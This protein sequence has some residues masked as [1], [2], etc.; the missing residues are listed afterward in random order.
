MKFN[1]CINLKDVKKK[2]KKKEQKGTNEHF[3]FDNEEELD[4]SDLRNQNNKKV[5]NRVQI[6]QEDLLLNVLNIN[7]RYL[8][9]NERMKNNDININSYIIIENLKN[10]KKI[11]TYYEFYNFTKFQNIDKS[12][13]KNNLINF[14][15]DQNVFCYSKEEIK[16]QKNDSTS[17]SKKYKKEHKKKTINI[18][19]SDISNITNLKWDNL[20]KNY[21]LEC[22][23]GI[24]GINLNIHNTD[25]IEIQDIFDENRLN[26]I[27]NKNFCFYK[28]IKIKKHKKVKNINYYESSKNRNKIK[29]NDEIEKKNFNDNIESYNEEKKKEEEYFFSEIINENDNNYNN[30]NN[31]ENNE[32]NIN[33]EEIYLLEKKNDLI[34]LKENKSSSEQKI[35][36]S[37]SGDFID[38]DIDK[39]FN[40]NDESK[41]DNIEENI[42]KGESEKENTKKNEDILDNKKEYSD[43]IFSDFSFDCNNSDVDNKIKS[44]NNKKEKLNYIKHDQV[45]SD[46]KLSEK[47]DFN[48]NDS[49]IGLIDDNVNDLEENLFDENYTFSKN[50]IQS[51]DFEEEDINIKLKDDDSSY[52]KRNELFDKNYSKSNKREITKDNSLLYDSNYD[53]K[54]DSANDQNNIDNL[55]NVNLHLNDE[56][57]II[58][59]FNLDKRRNGLLNNIYTYRNYTN[60]KNDLYFHAENDYKSRKNKDEFDYF[61]NIYKDYKNSS[62]YNELHLFGHNIVNNIYIFMLL[63]YKYI[64]N[65]NYNNSIYP[66]NCEDYSEYVFKNKYSDK[67]ILYD[68][69][70]INE[71]FN[72]NSNNYNLLS[73]NNK[74]KK[75]KKKKDEYNNAIINDEEYDH[76][77]DDDCSISAL[78]NNNFN[79]INNSSSLIN[80]DLFYMNINNYLNNR[81]NENYE[82]N[83][84]LDNFATIMKD[85][86]INNIRREDKNTILQ[87]INKKLLYELKKNTHISYILKNLFLKEKPTSDL[88]FKSLIYRYDEYKFLKNEYNNDILKCNGNV[89]K[90]KNGDIFDSNYSLV[91]KSE[92]RLH[93]TKDS[94]FHNKKLR[95]KCLENTLNKT[96]N[97][98]FFSNLKL[99]NYYKKRN[100]HEIENMLISNN[101]VYIHTRMS[102]DYYYNYELS[103]KRGIIAFSRFHKLDF[104][105]NIDKYFYNNAYEKCKRQEI[106]GEFDFLNVNGMKNE[107]KL[108]SDK[109]EKNFINKY[110]HKINKYNYLTNV[111]NNNDIN[112]PF[113][114]LN[115]LLDDQFDFNP[116][117][118][119]IWEIEN[120]YDNSVTSEYKNNKNSDN[121]SFLFFNNSCLLLNDDSPLVILE[122]L[123]KDPLVLLKIGMNSKLNHYFMCKDEENLYSFDYKNKLKKSVE[124]FGEINVINNSINYLGVSIKLKKSKQ[125][126]TFIENEL[127]KAFLF[128]IPIYQIDNKK[129]QKFHEI[130]NFNESNNQNINLNDNNVLLNSNYS[131]Y[132]KNDVIVNKDNVIMNDKAN[133]NTINDINYDLQ[134]NEKIKNNDMYASSD[135]NKK[136]KSNNSYIQNNYDSHLNQENHFY[137]TDFLLVRNFSNSKF[138][139]FL[140]PLY[141]DLKMYNEENDKYEMKKEIKGKNY[142]DSN[143]YSFNI[144]NSYNYYYR[145]EEEEKKK[146]KERNDNNMENQSE[147]NNIESFNN[148]YFNCIFYNVGFLDINID[149][150]NPL[151]KKYIGE[152][153]N[154]IR[155]WLIKLIIKYKIK[156]IKKIKEILKKKLSAFINEKDINAIVKSLDFN[157]LLSKSYLDDVDEKNYYKIKNVCMIE[158]VY[159]YLQLFKYEGINFKNIIEKEEKLN[160]LISILKIEKER[161]TNNII[162][163]KKKMNYIY[164]KYCY[165]KEAKA[166]DFDIKEENIKLPLINNYNFV[167]NSFFDKNM[168]N[169]LFYIKYLISYSPW[170]LL[171]DYSNVSNLKKKE[172]YKY[173]KK[174]KKKK[175]MKKKKDVKYDEDNDTQEGEEEEEIETDIE[176]KEKEKLESESESKSESELEIEEKEETEEEK[177]E[178]RE[179]ETE[180]ASYDIEEDSEEHE[181]QRDDKNETDEESDYEKEIESEKNEKEEESEKNEKEEESEKNEKEEVSEYEDEDEEKENEKE[182]KEENNF[183]EDEDENDEKKKKK[184]KVVKYNEETEDEEKKEK[185][186]SLK[187]K[188]NANNINNDEDF[189]SDNIHKNRKNSSC[190]NKKKARKN[191]A[192]A[193]Y[194]FNH[195]LYNEKLQHNKLSKQLKNNSTPIDNPT[196]FKKHKNNLISIKKKIFMQNNSILKRDI[197]K[198]GHELEK[199]KANH[200]FIKKNKNSFFNTRIKY[201]FS[202]F[203]TKKHLNQD[204]DKTKNKNKKYNQYD[205]EE[206]SKGDDNEDYEEKEK[207]DEDENYDYDLDDDINLNKKKSSMNKYKNGKCELKK[208][209]KRHNMLID[210][211]SNEKKINKDFKNI[212][213]FNKNYDFLNNIKSGVNLGIKDITK[214][215]LY[216]GFNIN[217]IKKMNRN[218]QISTIKKYMKKGALNSDNKIIYISMIKKIICEQFK[219][220]YHPVYLK[221]NNNILYINEK[222]SLLNDKK[223]S[224]LY[225]NEKH[226]KVYTLIK[227]KKKVEKNRINLIKSFFCD[228][229]SDSHSSHTSSSSSSLSSS[230]NLYSDKEKEKK[231]KKEKN[232]NEGKNEDDEEEEK[233]HLEI[234]REIQT[235]KSNFEDHENNY[236][237][238]HCL[239][240]TRIYIR[241]S[242]NSICEFENF[243]NNNI[244]ENGSKIKPSFKYSDENLEKIK[245][246]EKKNYSFEN[247]KSKNNIL[248][249]NSFKNIEKYL[250]NENNKI[251]NVQTLYIYGEQNINIFLKWKHFRNMLKRYFTLLN[252]KK[253]EKEDI[254]EEEYLKDNSEHKLNSYNEDIIHDENICFS[255][256]KKRKKKKKKKGLSASFK[257]ILNIFPTI[258]EDIKTWN[259]SKNTLENND[260]KNEKKKNN[261]PGENT[262]SKE[263]KRKI[264]EIYSDNKNVVSKKFMNT[265]YS[266]NNKKHNKNLHNISKDSSITAPIKITAKKN[267]I[268]KSKS[269]SQGSY[270][271]TNTI[272]E[273]EKEKKGDDKSNEE[274]KSQKNQIKKTSSINTNG[275]ENEEEK[276]TKKKRKKSKEEKEEKKTKKKSHEYNNNINL[277]DK[278]IRKTTSLS[279]G[280]TNSNVYNKNV[281]EKKRKKMK[282]GNTYNNI[283]EIIEKFN[284][285]LLIIMNEIS[286]VSHYKPFLNE[287]NETYAPMYYSV[288]KKPMYINKIIFRCR[289]RKY[290]NLNLF[291]DDVN[292]IVNNCKLYNTPTS[293]SSYLC[294]IVDNMF[295]EIVNKVKIDD[296]LQNYNNILTE[297]FYKNKNF[298]NTWE[299]FN[300]ENNDICNYSSN[301]FKKLNDLIINN[302][303]QEGFS[304]NS[305][306]S[307]DM[308]SDE[309]NKNSSILDVEMTSNIANFMNS[310]NSLNMKSCTLTDKLNESNI[311]YQDN[312]EDKEDKNDQEHIE[313]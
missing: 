90:K 124:P 226:N 271:K 54:N 282:K 210:R 31:T 208:K 40:F 43:S 302:A 108:Y 45:I 97:I 181:R 91:E 173:E 21:L 86:N 8:E 192:Y 306:L 16:V 179:K 278:S 311:S 222:K 217:D 72:S 33:K 166:I 132:N 114:I 292:L 6:N 154:Y 53:E 64:R 185:D 198:K 4:I 122:Y 110:D 171:K 277:T 65:Y 102:N 193:K 235:K 200:N 295:K 288:I 26:K 240:W 80:N 162:N 258:G 29:N 201:N 191:Y 245:E 212:K 157:F 188:N 199:N 32:S 274:K 96:K 223:I 148:N 309:T 276:K 138:K 142:K 286:Q 301:S 123:E 39:E 143:N 112:K 310:N 20:S 92:I 167:G 1:N 256:F 204:I 150:I 170:N 35:S 213:E 243:E 117:I 37:Y 141:V 263:K 273:H 93:N 115:I 303:K 308:L 165:K 287:V 224:N 299:C 249:K 197:N 183:E 113:D 19:T 137:Y 14:Y 68:E 18:A 285:N 126:L 3:L 153:R 44:S 205:D 209:K 237:L 250:V 55:N 196:D 107:G 111:N 262:D 101:N 264:N 221:Y 95:L 233:K 22:C 255:Q 176:K 211:Y 267:K 253:D 232:N 284:E 9:E 161:A 125:K 305:M 187:I 127:F 67:N 265:N 194:L 56:Q 13:E 289:K 121:Q 190:T 94:F 149:M 47:C 140:K 280:S 46:E 116:Y 136:I 219:N 268:S 24:N 7:K 2:K 156:D 25:F 195:I 172:N 82:D 281:E 77:N 275:K 61:K 230:K 216:L 266:M 128:T 79:I 178:E 98:I 139:F 88:L 227:K 66:F 296:N 41:S 83:I 163:A 236:K 27:K 307:L 168:L 304:N 155:S 248:L 120:N 164:E 180:R 244:D 12:Y 59:D 30:V 76:K 75:K 186:I 182:D 225:N 242:D 34:D 78:S 169:Y 36:K 291:F 5:E 118:I 214:T 202:Y 147:K 81:N 134:K 228:S 247:L 100:P 74:N 290:N 174:K 60:K 10:E 175:K 103:N 261:K 144:T 260:L 151:Y 207:D 50:K 294:V 160:K 177:Y 70:I 300:M 241:R 312:T 11:K 62:I 269:K 106:E 42:E 15:N 38:L 58:K 133:Y 48:N 298:Y 259:I 23:N 146:K 231:K 239:K 104:R 73:E 131:N 297:H 234:I 229:S 206:E 251:E 84:Y 252:N 135:F 119:N 89:E 57:E 215:L 130:D 279:E 189:I 152:K 220:L 218:E 254:N 17:I 203:H 145:E 85:L 293:L 63:N 52:T 313:N 129:E 238:I 49:I 99:D 184:K 158:C 272:K 283:K 51:K 246:D 257:N 87:R 105:T 159:H 109:E 28:D 71:I 69:N 270:N